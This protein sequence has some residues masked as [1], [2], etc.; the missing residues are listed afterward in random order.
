MPYR[1]CGRSGL[2]LPEISLGCW[3]N[4]GGKSP[5]ELQREMIYTAFD[6]GIT[7]FDLANN[8]GPPFGSA[9]INVGKIL[10]D[11]PRDEIIVSSKAGYDMWPG[12]YGE[13]GSRKYLIASLNQSLRRTDVEYFDIFYSHRFDPDTP[14]E[15]TLGALQTAVDQGKALY[16]GISSYS[17]SQTAKATELCAAH[18][19]NRIL[20]H[21]P[22]YSMFNRW[23]EESLASTCDENGIGMIAFCPLYQGLLTTKY[24]G[25]V[26]VGSRAQT[27]PNFL[28]PDD[29]SDEV[30]EVVKS[31]N[32]LAAD[33]GQTLA[34][35]AIAWILRLPQITSVLCGASRP[36]QVR[37]NC[38]AVTNK[39]FTEDE[40]KRIDE[41]TLDLTMPSSL[42]AKES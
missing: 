16:I 37:E 32:T 8:Y 2:K 31:L 26:P 3:H 7:H 40:L 15:E 24:L 39:D 9:E 38:A 41:L 19:W 29:L 18:G 11:L 13:W 25:G 14:L 30:L 42:W 21:Q 5:T 17:S 6:C 12:P 4:F 34:Q 27:N 28:R 35:M 20:I 22:N 23:V 36:E 10:K 1:R 33:R